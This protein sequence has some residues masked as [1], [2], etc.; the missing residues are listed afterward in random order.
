MQKFIVSVVMSDVGKCL[1]IF[2]VLCWSKLITSIVSSF[3]VTDALVAPVA[4]TINRVFQNVDVERGIKG[5][6]DGDCVSSFSQLVRPLK[7]LL[8]TK[9]WLMRFGCSMPQLWV[10]AEPRIGVSMEKVQSSGSREPYQI[11]SW[12]QLPVDEGTAGP[13]PEH[14]GLRL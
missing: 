3:F 4:F 10:G 6:A 14:S 5:C 1:S 2:C 11:G 12:C 9:L 8:E 13:S 7:I